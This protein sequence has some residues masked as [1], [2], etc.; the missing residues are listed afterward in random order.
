[1]KIGRCV[2]ESFVV[3]GKEGSTLDGTVYIVDNLS[4]PHRHP[5]FKMLYNRL[6]RYFI[7]ANSIRLRMPIKYIPN[8]V[9][10][11]RVKVISVL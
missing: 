6:S 7:A 3:I 1:M 10:L 5:K 2:K 9:T 8:I 11:V 4:F